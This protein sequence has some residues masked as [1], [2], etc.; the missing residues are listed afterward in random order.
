M[1]YRVVPRRTKVFFKLKFVPVFIVF[2][3]C[4]DLFP[5]R[6]CRDAEHV[7][8]K[9]AIQIRSHAQKFFAKV[10]RDSSVDAE[11]SSTPIA[12]PPP[13]P[14]KKPSRPYPRKI[15]DRANIEVT[16]SHQQEGTTDDVSLAKRENYS[17]TSVF[18]AIGSDNLESSVADV[19]KSRLSPASCATD[20]FSANDNETSNSSSKEEQG[21]RLPMKKCSALL[22]DNKSTMVYIQLYLCPKPLKYHLK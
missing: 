10:S 1:W 22:P 5:I 3:K 18:S 2:F 11:R 6:F 16:V 17:P 8:S 13:R 9:T 20:A 7:G 4:K 14:K 15:V 21:F 12:I 19:H